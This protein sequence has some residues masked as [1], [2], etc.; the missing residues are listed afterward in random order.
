M[1]FFVGWLDKNGLVDLNSNQNSPDEPGFLDMCFF[2]GGGV[3]QSSHSLFV[4][5]SD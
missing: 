1:I 3:V 5:L 2:L 4:D